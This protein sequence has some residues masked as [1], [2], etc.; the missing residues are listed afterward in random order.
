MQEHYD[1]VVGPDL[2]KKISDLMKNFKYYR[3]RGGKKDLRDYIKT[4]GIG[5]ALK[6]G[7]RVPMFKG[8][9]AWKKIY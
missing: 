6:E 3:E 8:G 1:K 5:G 9:A 7:G 2:D 4:W